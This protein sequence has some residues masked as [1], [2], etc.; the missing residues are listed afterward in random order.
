VSENPCIDLI[1]VHR[2]FEFIGTSASFSVDRVKTDLIN[3]AKRV[4]ALADR[5]PS[6]DDAG[7]D[8]LTNE[9]LFSLGIDPQSLEPINGALQQSI[10]SDIT[11]P[12]ND[13][14]PINRKGC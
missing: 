11:Y 12:K 5:Y 4:R 3:A 10:N 9:R 14:E 6:M 13:E 7:R 1:F 2:Q 8:D